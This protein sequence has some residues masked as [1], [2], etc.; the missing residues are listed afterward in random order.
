M[1]G[2]AKDDARRLRIGLIWTQFSAYHVDRLEAVGRRLSDRLDVVAIEVA[3]RSTTYAWEP[4]GTVA[5]TQK[6]QIFPG[7]VFER[8]PLV[9]RFIGQL[10]ELARCDHVFIGVAYSHLDI[11]LIAVILRLMGKRVVMMTASKFDDHPRFALKEWLKAQLLSCFS[12]AIVGGCRQYDYV[13]FLGFRRRRVLPGYNTVSMERVQRQATETGAA[14]DR[15]FAQRSFVFVGRFVAKK[16][17][18]TMLAAYADYADA[19]GSDA[20]RLTMVGDGP[21]ADALRAQCRDL[22]I[23][24]LVDFTGFLPSAQVS[25]RLAQGLALVLV[26]GEE[27]WGLVINE[28]LAVGLPVIASYEVGAREALVRN[29]QNGCLVQSGSVRS[30]ARA[31]AYVAADEKRWQT[32]ARRSRERAWL[33]DTERFAD[34]VELIVFPGQEPAATDH[35]RFVEAVLV[36]ANCLDAPDDA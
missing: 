1:S 14:F 29:L 36:E 17:I 22:N 11:I 8:I 9:R 31:F 4:S 26:S 2:R 13:R 15:P 6:R 5:H 34:A 16:N 30:I 27:Q 10:R 24:D 23:A 21:L 32:M 18:E 35:A 28:G 7:A 33:A 3:P 25:A 19:T 20:R 12:E